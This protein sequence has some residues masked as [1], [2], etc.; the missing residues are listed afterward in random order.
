M[1][2]L[3]RLEPEGLGS[4]E[5]PLAGSKQDG[6]HVERE[7]VDNSGGERLTHSR[8]AAGK[9][10]AAVAAAGIYAGAS[11][12]VSADAACGEVKDLAHIEPTAEV[13][14]ELIGAG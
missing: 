11:A 9:V 10:D 8:G 6:G 4:V 14:A 1:K 2:C 7:F 3:D 13:I 5:Q 12:L